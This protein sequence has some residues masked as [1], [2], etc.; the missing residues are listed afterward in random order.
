MSESA[1]Q[2]NTLIDHTN[3]DLE[4]TEQDIE[5]LI[6]EAAKHQFH[7][8]CIRSKWAPSFAKKYR[9]SVTI[10]F[11]KEPIFISKKNDIRPA[12]DKISKKHLSQK[13]AEV[14][15]ALEQGVLEI[16][17]VIGLKNLEAE[18]MWELRAYVKLLEEYAKENP[19]K[20]YW[21]KPIFSCELL[22]SARLDF[23]AKTFSSIVNKFKE[24]GGP[25]NIKFAFKNSTGFV[26]LKDG[27]EDD[28]KTFFPSPELI[29]IITTF[30]DKYD[31]EKHI[32]IK[33]AGGIKKLSTIERIVK[34]SNER[35]SHIGT[36]SG[37]D[38]V[39]EPALN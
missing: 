13:E 24:N 12:T 32:K 3:L 38:I 36:S 4:A 11:P 29:E 1:L 23:C 18:L 8:V 16:D 2:V 17:P 34:A 26:K 14:R 33:A 21:L 5:K 22:T 15:Q 27:A 6:Q 20:T 35:L 19:D 28:V 9:C 10:D 25:Q 37:L 31:P 7:S 30:L 39:S